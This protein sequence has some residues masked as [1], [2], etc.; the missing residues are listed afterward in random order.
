[1][2]LWT[3]IRCTHLAVAVVTCGTRAQRAR[4]VMEHDISN[5]V[6]IDPGIAPTHGMPLCLLALGCVV[7]Y[8]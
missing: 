1:M 7:T 2:Q 6:D 5:E 4:I 3:E 8:S